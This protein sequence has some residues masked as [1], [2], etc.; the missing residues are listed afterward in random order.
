MRNY[1]SIAIALCATLLFSAC[2]GNGTLSV[3]RYENSSAKELAEGRNDSLS[4]KASVEYPESGLDA[5]P[6]QYIQEQIK[7]AVYGDKYVI[8]DVNDGF[9]ACFNDLLKNYRETNLA[10]L[11][12][13]ANGDQETAFS[14]SWEYVTTGQFTGEY[15]N[16]V[17]Y[18]VSNY[19][20]TG[21][22]HGL[23]WDTPFVFDKKTGI[24]VDE[25]ELFIDDYKAPLAELLTKHSADNF[26]NPEDA[27]F[28]VN[29]IV[30]N[31]LFEVSE[32]GVT[33]SYNPY[34][35]APYSTG[36]VK[37]TVPWDELKDVL[38]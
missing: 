13:S 11:E 29:E 36:I 16:M 15:K 24:K 17:S 28:F 38:R 1:T 35:I 27:S 7:E 33:Y 9:A 19:A 6:L 14:L 21:G 2:S 23:S 18:T 32:Q 34:E 30:P 22:A 4:F 26:D 25:S 20:Y 31:G 8:L 5:K 12:D 3:T 37:I 10:M